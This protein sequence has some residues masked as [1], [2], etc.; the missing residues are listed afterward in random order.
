MI[1]LSDYLAEFLG[2][3][4]QVAH[5]VFLVS[6]GGLMH[7]LDSVGRCKKLRY[8]CNHHEQACSIAAEGFARVSNKIGIAFVT[9]GPGGTNAITGVMGA[10]VD[11]IPMMV[12]SGQV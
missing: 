9:T 1:K 12:V 5:D 8:I 6:G 4:D 7:L 11:S 10:W 2:N 3:S